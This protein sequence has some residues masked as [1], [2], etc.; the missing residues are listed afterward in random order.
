[1]RVEPMTRRLRHLTGPKAIAVNYVVVKNPPESP[2]AISH[3]FEW[4]Y[5]ASMANILF[6]VLHEV[7]SL[8]ASFRLAND[9]RQR[10]HNVA[11]AGVADSKELVAANG[12]KFTSLFERFFPQ[13]AVDEFV[14]HPDGLGYFA[15][16]PKKYSFLSSFVDALLA[17]D[18]EEVFSTFRRLEPDLILFS[19]GRYAEW[20]ALMAYS[21][22][23]PSIYLGSTLAPRRGSGLPPM[24]SGL[25]P[26]TG[27][28]PW[29]TFRIW[30][31][32][33]AHD[34][35]MGLH[36][37]G[38]TG[39]TRRLAKKYRIRDFQRKEAYGGEIR[40]SLPEIIPFPHY[41]DFPSFEAPDQYHIEPSVSLDR[42]DGDF[43]WDRLPD[44]APLAY[45]GLGTFRW[46]P[47]GEYLRFFRAV[48]GA[49]AL[50]PD[51]RWVVA[52]GGIVGADELDRTPDN[53][54]LVN[55][56][57][58]L[59]LLTRA[60]VMI[61]HA[62]ANSVKESIFLGVPTVLFPLD[63]DQPGVAA[64]AL[65]HGVAVAGDF[66]TVTAEK[67]GALIETA[68][69]SPYIKGQLRVMRSR[70]EEAQRA[71]A[72]VALIESLLA[73][74]CCTTEVR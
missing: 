32:W 39:L 67:L 66:R 17:G 2:R 48:I 36:F 47:K 41:F 61:G 51:W 69:K 18:D 50:K 14:D 38:H 44:D 7:G 53:V 57:P 23:L 70:F 63:A 74:K 11:Y 28:S 64:R 59:Q 5:A 3:T 6:F 27:G 68:V 8:N 56:A 15:W 49:A 16:L 52:L 1:M 12:Y 33:V 19:G 55:Y 62:G 13:G 21:L 71:G 54:I 26:R 60:C 25:I 29:Q 42:V 4:K 46:R 45:C 24:S 58:Q 30:L 37:L 40:V 20:P 65:Y 73:G 43:P 22:G 31:S 34:I 9:L 35:K 72:G 10:G